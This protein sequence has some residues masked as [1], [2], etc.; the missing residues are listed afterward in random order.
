MSVRRSLFVLLIVVL[1]LPVWFFNSQVRRPLRADVER[2]SNLQLYEV[3]PADVA[4]SVS[5][6][7]RLEAEEVASLSFLVPGRVATL[8]VQQDDYVLQGDVLAELD[9]TLQRI[10]Y[11]QATLNLE[12]TRLDMQDMLEPDET[13]ITL[14]EAAVNSAWGAYNSVVNSVTDGDIRSAELAYE[15]AV[16]AIDIARRARDGVGGLFGGDSIQ[17]EQ[18]NA[19]YGEA[20]FNAEIARLQAEQ[21]R[22]STAPGATA[23]YRGVLQAQAELE[24]VK[25]GPPPVQIEAAEISIRQAENQVDRAETAFN[26]TRLIAPFDGVISTLNAEVGALVAPG[27]DVVQLADVSPL[28]LTIQVDE[29]DLGLIAVGMPVRVELDALPDVEFPARLQSI[30][31]ISSNSGGIVNYA[32][33]VTLE[34]EDPRARVGM[35]AEATIIIEEST[36]V[37]TVP[38]LYIRLER[39]AVNNTERAFVNV[40]Q[41]DNTL[42]EVEI[43]LGLRGQE[44]SE[45]ISGLQANDLI[46]IDPSGGGLSSFIGF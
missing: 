17:W 15:Q 21:L 27:V 40:L 11:E 26:R 29:I 46:A 20:T 23:A 39:D 33:G 41:D 28:R 45:V 7:G 24:R 12:R 34:V 16:E 1:I 30:A 37:L 13:Q 22:T 18:A 19:R 42:Q 35:T 9:N 5:A 32:V 43:E 10:A 25:A 14:A 6:I 3:R 4:L 2:V 38:N 8:L 44:S 36:D 31:P